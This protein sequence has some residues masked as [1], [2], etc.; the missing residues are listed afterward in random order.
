MKKPLIVL[1]LATLT[2]AAA[3]AG[4]APAQEQE[5]RP[6]SARATNDC[7]PEGNLRGD[8]GRGKSLHAENCAGCHGYDGK[9]E[10]VVMHMDTMPKD[11][12]DAQYMKTLPDPYL[13]LAI[14][15]GGT[16]VGKNL[17]MAP[18][19]G[20]LSDQDIRDLIAWVRT[21]SGT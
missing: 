3:L 8:I 12:S 10:V 15:T 4:E 13:Y 16:N 20:I 6:G 14:C 18:W 1:L 11:Q 5:V 17:I 19:G 21:F 9:A 2:L 7:V